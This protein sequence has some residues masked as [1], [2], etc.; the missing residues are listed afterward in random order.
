MS[1]VN[2]LKANVHSQEVLYLTLQF[3][4]DI[5]NEETKSKLE[6]AI[7]GKFSCSWIHIKVYKQRMQF[8]KQGE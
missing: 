3:K 7:A 6:V 2:R 4:G 1:T 5:T 8:S